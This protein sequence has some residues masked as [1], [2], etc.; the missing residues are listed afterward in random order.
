MVTRLRKNIPS[1]KDR[2][3][4]ILILLEPIDKLNGGMLIAFIPKPFEDFV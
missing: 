1:G 2:V 3:I 4:R